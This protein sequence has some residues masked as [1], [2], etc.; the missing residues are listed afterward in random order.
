MTK[1]DARTLHIGARPLFGDPLTANLRLG[2][3]IGILGLQPKTRR[4]HRLTGRVASVRSDGFTI[5][6]S[7]AYGNCPQYIQTRAVGDLEEADSGVI[8]PPISRS[9]ALD[10]HTRMMIERADSLF[11][12][13]AYTEC[14]DAASQGADVAH[15]GGKPGFVNVEGDRTFVFPDFSG[16]NHF[17]TVGNILLNPKA[18]FLF[19]DL[20]TRDLV[21]MAGAASIV[22]KGEEVRAFAGPER[23]DA[24]VQTGETSLTAEAKRLL[25]EMKPVRNTDS[26][27]S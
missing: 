18:G 16:N 8:E 3:D 4:R 27:G 15:R 5:A 12:A 7:Q 23:L 6:I 21:Y 1:P 19:V 2:T 10:S 14:G 20:E 25:D 9:N 22:W 11:I 13:T 17:N 24:L 26:G